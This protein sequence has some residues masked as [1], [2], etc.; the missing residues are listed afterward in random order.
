MAFFGRSD[1]SKEDAIADAINAASTLRLILMDYIFPSLNEDIGE[2]IDLGVR[3][4]L[5]YG[6]EEE[7][8]WGIL[9]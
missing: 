8:I 4:G 2:K 6:S 9:A 5:D 7:V 1:I 3:I